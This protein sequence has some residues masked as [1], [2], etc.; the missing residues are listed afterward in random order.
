MTQAVVDTTPAFRTRLAELLSRAE[1]QAAELSDVIKLGDLALTTLLDTRAEAGDFLAKWIYPLRQHFRRM[2]ELTRALADSIE[3]A[4]VA[5]TAWRSLPSLPSLPPDAARREALLD[6]AATLLKLASEN[7]VGPEQAADAV[8]NP[9]AGLIAA[10]A[11]FDRL[12]AA[13]MA[14]LDGDLPLEEYHQRWSD[15]KE[16]ALGEVWSTRAR[17]MDGIAARVRSLLRF[18]PDKADPEA[19]T[20]HY[21]DER[22]VAALLRDLASLLQIET[23]EA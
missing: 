18:V 7:D 6:S 20:N 5:A 2:D 3:R 10:I 22:M 15:K 13:A 14:D 11:A 16:R 12:D 19:D 21:M 1:T 8:D 23:P 9:D 17:T 4:G